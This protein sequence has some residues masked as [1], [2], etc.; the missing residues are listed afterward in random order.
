MSLRILTINVPAG[1]GANTPLDVAGTVFAV[2]ETTAPFSLSVNGESPIGP[3][4]RGDKFRRPYTQ[5]SFINLTAVALTVK[6][7]VGNG[8]YEDF[9]PTVRQEV[10]STTSAIWNGVAVTG[11]TAVTANLIELANPFR[12]EVLAQADALNVGYIVLQSQAAANCGIQV[13]LPGEKFRIFYKG[14]IYARSTN[15]TDILALVVTQYV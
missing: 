15:G 7:I 12:V 6:V 3:L 13:L 10:A 9:R 1:I 5:V 4:E 2:R 11:M 8:E 14:A